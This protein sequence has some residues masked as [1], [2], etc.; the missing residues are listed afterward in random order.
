M[1]EGV[2]RRVDGAGVVLHV[3]EHGPRDAPTVVLLHGYPDT[4]AV[5]D[6]VVDEL[7]AKFHIATYDVR[8]AGR[9]EG[10]RRRE[11]YRLPL[12]ME[13]LAAVLDA[14]SPDR[15]V[16]LV[17][18]DWGSLQGWE[19]ITTPALTGRIAS[20]T[21]ISGPS[22]DHVAAWMRERARRRT[23]RAVRELAGQ[24][25][26]S[27]YIAAF[28]VPGAPIL[29]G[30]AQ[31]RAAWGRRA[32]AKRLERAEHAAVDAR[33][34]APTFARDLANGINLYRANIGPKLRGASRPQTDVPV[35]L[36]VST[37]DRYVPPSLLDGLELASP[38]TWRRELAAGHWVMRSQPQA[39]ARCIGELV[40][41]VE[42]AA[43]P[44][45]LA[46]AR[47]HSAEGDEAVDTRP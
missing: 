12:L 23:P 36:L 7:A 34:P 14:V 25:V 46:A 6:L 16:H 32:W 21:S 33:W 15:G 27:S 29:A 31:R 18:H 37:A 40:E 38:R 3:E 22:L 9:S 20:Y 5:W 2:A 8:G 11:Q 35:Q 4:S 45:G 17:G 1:D 30:L 28:H 19:A 26:R 42:G 39:L 13:D 41:H 43:E 24:A 44:S 47:V 10:P